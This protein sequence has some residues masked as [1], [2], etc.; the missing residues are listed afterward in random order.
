MYVC[1][2]IDF[3]NICLLILDYNPS[4][5]KPIQRELDWISKK[6]DDNNGG[7]N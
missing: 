6:A 3:G 2:F 4:T 7:A 5:D 1:V